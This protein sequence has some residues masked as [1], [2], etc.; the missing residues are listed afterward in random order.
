MSTRIASKIILSCAALLLAAA[1]DVDFITGPKLVKNG[2]SVQ[3]QILIASRDSS[4]SATVYLT[5]DVPVGWALTAAQFQS[6]IA[7]GTWGD[8][9]VLPT[10]P[11][12]II[13]LP[14][15]PA[16]HRRIYLS[17]GPFGVITGTDKGTAL[18]SFTAS[19]TQGNYTM[20]FWAGF[21][22]PPNNTGQSEEPYSLALSVL[23]P[24]AP[25]TILADGFQDG[26]TGCWSRR[27]G[28]DSTTVAYYPLDGSA[29]DESVFGNDGTALGD[30]IFGTDRF[31]AP[32]A[33][34]LFDGVDDQIIVA[35]APS[36]DLT[37]ELTLAA[38]VKPAAGGNPYV[39][40]KV[41]LSD[42]GFLYSL[43]YYDG[44]INGRFTDAQGG[45]PKIEGY[46][47][48]QAD[49]W[50][51]LVFTWDGTDMV[52]SVDGVVEAHLELT[53]T[54]V[55]VGDGDVEIGSYVDARYRGAMD[56]LLIVNR[57]LTYREVLQLLQ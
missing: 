3:Y 5:G 34:M 56:D 4:S 44:A 17:A 51:L 29:D 9:T 46:L 1:C 57:A 53:G 41:N 15:V 16:G 45:H 52:C 14:P 23:P 21:S 18:L 42:V 35:N 24:T 27:Q 39:L 22:S 32:G 13:D 11:G 12:V 36:L 26:T 49:Q 47:P 54:T 10:D 38:W 50:Q 6:S 31:G 55:G 43:D 20:E 40:G 30:P 25:N 48:L 19:G 28:V 7:G 8:L 2:E 33:A 37:D